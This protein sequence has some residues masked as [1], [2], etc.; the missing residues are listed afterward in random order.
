MK[1][2]EEKKEQIETLLF[3][4]WQRNMSDSSKQKVDSQ[5]QKE[6]SRKQKRKKKRKDI[7]EEESEGKKKQRAIMVFI[8]TIIIVVLLLFLFRACGRDASASP[9]NH[10]EYEEEQKSEKE[11]PAA[12]VAKNRLNLAVMHDYEVSK[13]E[14]QFFFAY[15]DQNYYEI[16]MSI[17]NE[18][19]T[20][21]YRTKR[22]LP[23]TQVGIPGYT[24]LPQGK[25][26]LYAV[27]SAYDPKTHGLISEAVKMEFSVMKK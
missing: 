6:D 8:F 27:I 5:F 21:V 22:I 10:P 23:G 13:K 4:N 19:G 26:D 24:F 20:E 25:N 2:D 16:E 1:K 9:D 14:E 15:A 3:E 12:D 17:R 18:E 7:S 11:K